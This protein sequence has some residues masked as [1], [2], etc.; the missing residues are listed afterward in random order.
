VR[1]LSVRV[2]LGLLGL[3]AVSLLLRSTALHGRYWIDEGLSVGIAS[4]PLDEIPAALRQDGSPPLYY[5]LLGVWTRLVGDGEARTHALSLLFALLSVPAAFLLAR[6]L[7]AERVAWC[8]AG[9]AALMPF[10]SYYAQET[11][12]Y[13]LAALL[14][15]LVAGS[16]AL[17]F[18][19]GRRRWLAVFAVSG[20]ALLYTHNWGLFM[21][22]GT[23]LALLP[24]LRA[25]R[26]PW[27]DALL[28][29]GGVA[30]LYLPWLPTLLYQASHTGAPW[31]ELPA[32][33][34]VPAEI[35]AVVGG[36]GAQPAHDLGSGNRKP[37]RRRLK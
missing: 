17:A 2:A 26:V 30:V 5:L 9:V 32:P 33:A 23:G 3:I 14:S 37:V 8:A 6:A 7:F 4:F 13:A 24:A 28:G 15:V 29:Y 31:S 22:A 12:M 1:T 11:R 18:L 27:R 20:A 10:L 34:D 19:D 36:E 21:L 25:R 16:Y 35:A